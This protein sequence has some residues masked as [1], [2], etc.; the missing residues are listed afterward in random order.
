M[1]AGCGSNIPGDGILQS[2]ASIFQDARYLFGHDKGARNTLPPNL[3]A[4][5]LNAAAQS[6]STLSMVSTSPAKYSPSKLPTFLQYAEDKLG[7]KGATWYKYTLANSGFG[8]DILPFVDNADIIACGIPAGDVIRLKRGASDWWN[9]PEAKRAH[10][11]SPPVQ[12]RARNGAGN[13]DFREHIRFE[14]Q[15]VE[16]GCASVFGPAMLPGKN[17]RYKEFT[18]WYFDQNFKELRKVSD[19]LIPEID[20]EYLDENAP[21]FEP[22]P[23]PE[24]E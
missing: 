3:P 20:P 17:R 12:A 18:W 21:L 5:P 13:D 11:Q 8:P 7:V 15:F 19:G 23:S 14:K 1:A 22:S 24:P 10:A 2:V 9:S 4:T 6:S 16:G